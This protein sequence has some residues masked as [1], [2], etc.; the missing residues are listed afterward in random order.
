MTTNREI[1]LKEVPAFSEAYKGPRKVE[2]EMA[3]KARKAVKREPLPLP[4]REGD[5]ITITLPLPDG[6]LVNAANNMHW[7]TKSRLVKASREAAALIANIVKPPKPWQRAR[8]DV[9]G[10][11]AKHIDPS[12]YWNYLKGTIDGCQDAGLFVNDSAVE[13]GEITQHTGK[14]SAGKRMV[15]VKITRTA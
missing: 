3:K 12:N 7:Q 10:W 2:K 5:T 13:T 15:V 14:Q 1:W 11:T 4:T 8:I 6:R 9:E